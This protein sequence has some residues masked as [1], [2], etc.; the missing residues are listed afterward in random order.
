V[1]PIDRQDPA[2]RGTASRGRCYLYVLPCAYEDL[3]KLGFSRDPLARMQA[4]HPRWFEFF[5]LDRAFLVET[6]SVR[7]ARVL[8]LAQRRALAEYNAP[9]PL[10]VSEAAGG[11][12][13]WYR[14]AHARLEAAAHA[15]AA[16]G[17]VIH[18]PLRPFARE[19][20]LAR[21]PLL[22]SWTQ[23]MLTVDDLEAGIAATPVQRAVRDA[24]DAHVA[25]GIDLEPLLPPAVLRWHRALA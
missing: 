6:E 9:V 7:D 11:H 15:L 18:A 3:L 21:A 12:R 25:L 13:E 24:L 1:P 5:D 20:L 8:E 22:F 2:A 19:A 10:T 23:A 14:G 17:Y 4:L 16:D